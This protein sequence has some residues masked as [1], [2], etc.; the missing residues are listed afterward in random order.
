MTVSGALQL[1]VFFGFLL[2]LTK[3]LGSYLARVF[4]GERT[5]LDRGLGWLERGPFRVLGIDPREDMR[6]TAYASALLLFSLTSL[7]FSYVLLRL[8]G[9]LPL[10]PQVF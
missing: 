5:I 6:W 1:I 4:E 3:P 8:H 2:L 9:F 7:L 10:N